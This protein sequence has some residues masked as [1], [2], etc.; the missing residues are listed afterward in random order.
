LYLIF[1][2]QF[3]QFIVVTYGLYI[4]NTTILAN[5]F[6]TIYHWIVIFVLLYIP[7]AIYIGHQHYQKQY[8]AETEKVVQSDPYTFK[9]TPGKEQLFQYPAAVLGYE[10]SIK[11][12]RWMNGEP[13]KFTPDEF[14]KMEQMKSTAER[15]GNGENILDI[16]K[17]H[18]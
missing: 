10:I 14:K 9:P 16:L 2:V 12:M 13:V 18:A 1:A 15:L 6:P 8:K 7:T 4:Q 5:L 3:V 17:E 11:M